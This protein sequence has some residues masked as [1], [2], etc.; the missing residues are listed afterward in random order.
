MGINYLNYSGR[1]EPEL[2]AELW[3]L[4]NGYTTNPFQKKPVCENRPEELMNALDGLATIR[5][6]DVVDKKSQNAPSKPKFVFRPNPYATLPSYKAAEIL[7]QKEEDNIL[8]AELIQ[9]DSNE[10]IETEDGAMTRYAEL[11]KRAKDYYEAN[12]FDIDNEYLNIDGTFKGVLLNTE[13]NEIALDLPH[14]RQDE[15][16]VPFTINDVVYPYLSE[17]GTL[18]HTTSTENAHAIKSFGFDKNL[19]RK[20]EVSADGISFFQG[21]NQNDMEGKETIEATYDG[22]LCEGDLSQ[23]E[24][25]EKKLASAHEEDF[26]EDFG[27]TS[28]ALTKVF[29]QS[30]MEEIGYDGIISQTQEGNNEVIAFDSDKISIE[31]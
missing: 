3:A 18:Y 5:Y 2:E 28:G 31:A 25:L 14:L 6:A 9:D 16:F 8:H 19:T 29:L 24:A 10:I 26:E 12:K 13:T 1:L 7:A 15:R 20:K 17:I 23:I 27:D 30:L 11:I 21:K 22:K 4:E